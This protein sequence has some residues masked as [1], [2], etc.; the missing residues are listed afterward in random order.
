MNCKTSGVVYRITC[1]KCPEFVYI[2]E[3]GRPL[4]QRFSEHQR[5]AANKD[6]TKPSGKHFSLPGHSETDMCIIG[7]EQVL[8][9]EDALLRKTRESY[10]INLYQSID[11]GGNSRS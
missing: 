11:F 9:K 5:D 4:K 7:I 8:P 2:G 1:K 3:T 10:W 6:I